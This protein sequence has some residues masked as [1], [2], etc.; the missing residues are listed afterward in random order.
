MRELSNIKQG[1]GKIFE[2]VKSMGATMEINLEDENSK[3][4]QLAS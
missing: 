1:L 2:S 4:A 3:V